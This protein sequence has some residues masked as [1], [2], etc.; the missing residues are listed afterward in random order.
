MGNI[1]HVLIEAIYLV[2]ENE[3]RK[4][5]LTFGTRQVSLELTTTGLK[6][7]HFRCWCH[8]SYP[9]ESKS[10]HHY[11]KCSAK[12]R[13]AG[14]VP[15]PLMESPWPQASIRGSRRAREATDSLA[16]RQLQVV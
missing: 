6:R 8:N 12:A 16:A 10:V 11:R 1:F 14:A 2:N 3:S 9:P 5:P 4:G 13:N 15:L 7:N